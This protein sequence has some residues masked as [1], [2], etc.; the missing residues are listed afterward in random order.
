MPTH[1]ALAYLTPVFSKVCLI[2]TNGSDQATI[3]AVIHTK[4]NMKPCSEVVANPAYAKYYEQHSLKNDIFK[5]L[6]GYSGFCAELTES[7][8]EFGE[9][10][11][12]FNVSFFELNF[13]PCSLESGCKPLKNLNQSQHCCA[14]LCRLRTF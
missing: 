2:S 8:L 9:D 6:S 13:Y 7:A 10:E 5:A 3:T 14:G 11:D 4:M 12:E 1:E